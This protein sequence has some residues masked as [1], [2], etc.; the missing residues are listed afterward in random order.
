MQGRRIQK[1][2]PLPDL[3]AQSK[4]EWYAHVEAEL[5]LHFNMETNNCFQDANENL[6]PPAVRKKHNP[7]PSIYIKLQHFLLTPESNC[8]YTNLNPQILDPPLV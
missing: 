8:C 3:P 2:C 4:R 1:P 6:K 7:N 5:L